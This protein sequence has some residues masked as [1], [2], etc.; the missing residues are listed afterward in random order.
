MWHQA[1]LGLPRSAPSVADALG[2]VAL[3]Q[4][5]Q[6]ERRSVIVALPYFPFY[7]D[8]WLGSGKIDLIAPEQEGAYIRLLARS[9]GCPDCTLPNDE[10]ILLRWS[11]LKSPATLRSLL[12]ICFV[13][14]GDGC[15]NTVLRGLWGKA[16]EKH[17][18]AVKSAKC[19][20]Y[21][22]S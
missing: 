19:R 13:Q 1:S 2:I 6:P 12:K 8:R 10:K 9:W 22:K 11:R 14:T 21:N 20:E 15:Q 4:D 3:Y 7:P 18:K 17:D 16:Q 5:L